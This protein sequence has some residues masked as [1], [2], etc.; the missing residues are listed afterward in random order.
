MVTTPTP[1]TATP[2]AGE[3]R[4]PKHAA[5]TPRRWTRSTAFVVISVTL[6]RILVGWGLSAATERSAPVGTAGPSVRGP[7]SGLLNWDAAHYLFTAEHGYTSIYTAP[8]LP[9]QPLLTR[10][11]AV[12]LGYP[13]ATIF[14]SWVALGFAVWGVFEL[15]NRLTS[16]RGAVGAALLFA[17]NPV[18]V[19]LIAGYAES[20]FVALTAWCLI[21][22]RDRRW[23][24][25]A[26]LAGGA[27]ATVPQ[28][29]F[30]GVVVVVGIVLAE[31][32]VRRLGLAVGCGLLSEAGILAYSWFC[33]AHWH[34][35]LEWK[36]SAYIYGHSRLSIPLYNVD[37]E[38]HLIDTHPVYTEAH[39]I[40][41]L[42]ALA[43]ILAV[44]ALA[45]AIVQC[46]RDHRWILPTLFLALAGG[47]SVSTT[48]DWG[49]GIA[50]YVSAIVT[51]YVVA[52]IFFDR[53]ARRRYW[54]IG[55]ALLPVVAIALYVEVQF[56]MAHWVT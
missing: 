29:I 41:L 45:V 43:A 16:R 55:L 49:D 3:R 18:S 47:L 1:V 52:A 32:G 7:A 11:V 8:W 14:V 17:W 13:N 51:M 15:A 35:A 25:A 40:L 37:F 10:P 20:L 46:F 36:D 44:G 12:V 50:R 28:G 21:F 2:V 53:L 34:N 6:T 22:C 23:V 4:T 9:L 54:Y 30:A 26:L 42:N 56:H 19:F 31:R 24:W 38:A 5:S 27:S 33:W 48:N 39:F